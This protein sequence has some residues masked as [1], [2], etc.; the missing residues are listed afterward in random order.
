MKETLKKFWFVI[1]VACL[2]IVAVVY[3]GIDQNKGLLK[4][5]TSNGS[6]VVYS[7]NGEDVTADDLYEEYYETYGED[8]VS[9]LFQRTVLD[10]TV[11]TTDEMEEEANTEGEYYRSSYVNYYGTE[12]EE[13]LQQQVEAIGF[14]SIEEYCLYSLKAEELDRDYVL[15]HTDIWD[16]FKNE[17]A[18]RIV[19]HALI[20]MDDVEN[21]TEEE[22]AALEEA[23]TAWASGDFTFEE[24][25]QQY[26]DDS[27]SAVNGGYIG[28]IDTESTD[29]YVEEFVEAAVNTEVGGYS[30]WFASSYG[31][32]IIYVSSDSMEDCLQEV[33][34]LE[35][36]LTMYPNLETAA[37]WDKAKELGVSFG[38]DEIEATI[39]E[40]LGVDEETDEVPNEKA[41][42]EDSTEESSDEESSGTEET[43]TESSTEESSTESSAEKEGSSNE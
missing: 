13:Y 2:F 29:T 40:A 16:E 11:K 9:V 25:A 38:S 15:N 21:P 42:E 20:L 34:C 43:S 17:Y 22:L 24:F 39:R 1:L 7:F 12:G 28:Y 33:D 14:S 30:E 41:S 3:F 8:A 32:H 26:S 5:K 35:R 4:G 23:K 37:L 31:Y 19:Y 18:P 10:Q 36:I 6:G 27:S